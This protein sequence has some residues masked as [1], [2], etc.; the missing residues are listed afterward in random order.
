MNLSK[1]LIHDLAKSKYYRKVKFQIRGRG[2]TSTKI[3]YA[4]VYLATRILKVPKLMIDFSNL[5]KI[6]IYSLYAIYKDVLAKLNFDKDIVATPT[7]LQLELFVEK[8]YSK[9]KFY[10]NSKNRNAFI[11][12]AT[13]ILK[14][15]R[16][17]SLVEG[18]NPRGII[19]AAVYI[20]AKIRGISISIE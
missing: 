16:R 2:K 13:K 12:E 4:C 6:S 10:K 18:R 9:L 14:W 20:A 3:I 11:K 1:E 7:S 5:L 15:F 19:G 17:D 8:Y